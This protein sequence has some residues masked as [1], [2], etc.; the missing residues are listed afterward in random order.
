MSDGVALLKRKAPET[1][2]AQDVPAPQIA[3]MH[4]DNMYRGYTPVRT[5]SLHGGHA[6]D[7]PHRAN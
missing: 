4:A 1:A 2:A 5:H 3:K 7:D 6:S